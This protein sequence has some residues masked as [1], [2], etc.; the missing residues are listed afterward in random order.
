MAHKSSHLYMPQLPLPGKSHIN[1][2]GKELTN[3]L[4][5]VV[6]LLWYQGYTQELT[7]NLTSH[8][9]A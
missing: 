5:T 6:C 9:E 2:R 1:N 4:Q 7:G 8:T 3:G